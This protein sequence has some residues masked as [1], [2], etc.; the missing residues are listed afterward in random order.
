[1]EPDVDRCELGNHAI[2]MKSN[3]FHVVCLAL[4]IGLWVGSPALAQPDP[5]LG[6]VIEHHAVA[7]EQEAETADGPSWRFDAGGAIRLPGL[8]TLRHDI[9]ADWFHTY[10]GWFTVGRGR[11]RLR[12]DY[13]RYRQR[14][15]Y[16]FYCEFGNCLRTAVQSH[17]TFQTAIGW[18]FRRDHRLSPHLHLGAGFLQSGIELCEKGD[19]WPGCE[20]YGGGTFTVVAG[21]GVDLS[22]GSRFFVRVQ[23]QGVTAPGSEYVLENL[24]WSALSDVMVGGGVRF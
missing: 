3:M 17:N 2:F 13:V 8:N 24:G 19:H 16:E 9:E 11:I 14:W 6:G 10:G 7:A 5:L 20:E 22:V 23:L 18:H 15:E 1:M 21:G 12:V 4:A